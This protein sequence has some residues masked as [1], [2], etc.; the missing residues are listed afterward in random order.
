MTA[1]TPVDKP[2]GTANPTLL[3]LTRLTVAF[4][5][6]RSYPASHPLVR[7]AETQAFD[8]LIAALAKR[9]RMTVSIGHGEL[10]LDD[11]PIEQ[12][13]AVASELADKL[14]RRGVGSLTFDSSVSLESLQQALTWLALE[15]LATEGH[16]PSTVLA[17]STPGIAIARIAYER[18]ELSSGHTDSVASGTAIWRTLSSAALLSDEA[19]QSVGDV[20]LRA[21]DGAQGGG[22]GTGGGSGDGSGS[23]SGSAAGPRRGAGIG[24]GDLL[25]ADDDHDRDAADNSALSSPTDVADAIES[26]IAGDGYAKRVSFG[27]LSVSEQIAH[28]DEATRALLSDRLR[29]VLASLQTSSLGAIIKSAGT[30][31]SQR[32]F[33]SQVVDAL[34]AAAIIE[35][36]ETAASATGQDLSHHMLRMLGKLSTRTEGA[37]AAADS[38]EA[39]RGAAQELV[40][41]WTLDDPNPPDHIALLDH[42]SLFDPAL[43]RQSLDDVG[44]ARVVQIALEV[45]TFG[46]DAEDATNRLLKDGR[47]VDLLAWVEE[48]PGRHAAS[49]VQALVLSPSAIKAVLLGDPYDQVVGRA[50]L[51]ELDINASST[52]LDVLRDATGRTARRMTYDRMKEFGPDLAPELMR[53]LEGAPWYFV[54]NLLALLRDTASGDG[55]PSDA[56]ASTLLLFL[57]HQQEQ[58]R[59]E[60]LRLLLTDPFARDAAIRRVLDDPSDRVVRVALESLTGTERARTATLAPELVQRLLEFIRA[61]AHHQD[62]L[63]RAIRTL[64]DA[65]T[66]TPVR[67]LLLSLTSRRSLLLRRLQLADASPI[68]VPALEVLAQRYADD[69]TSKQVIELARR[70]KDRSI[71]AAVHGTPL[72]GSRPMPER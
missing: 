29:S 23:G 1:P 60:A 19:M 38:E 43:S 64:L 3:L 36:L 55:G 71:R 34:P 39:F 47:M 4:S 52:L 49:A 7:T 15:P 10:L 72:R 58:V 16:D 17:P 54:R 35:W 21:S 11:A 67:E 26:R 59:V 24:L 63:A 42:I 2:T 46:A 40:Q 9:R 14:R 45:D 68:V 56:S 53:R 48:A 28:A 70:S 13:G 31:A 18:L 51:A 6:R 37:T 41:G 62:L 32:R 27:L 25:N 57:T 5:R 22:G 50:L 33:V 44:A 8:S 30:A 20:R 69:A 12:G 65:P 61:K 66:S